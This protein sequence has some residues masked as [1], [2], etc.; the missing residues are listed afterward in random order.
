MKNES[1]KKSTNMEKYQND[2]II[3]TPKMATR[4]DSNKTVYNT[5]NL[6]L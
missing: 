6:C 2:Q 4:H 3:P 5:L 1:K